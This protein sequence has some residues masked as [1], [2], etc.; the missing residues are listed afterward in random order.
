M[1]PAQLDHP[2]VVEPHDGVVWK[3]LAEVA[4]E[5]QNQIAQGHSLTLDDG[6]IDRELARASGAYA[7]NAAA[8][9]AG[10][11]YWP[12]PGHTWQPA[13]ARRDLVRSAALAIAEIERLDRAQ[14]V[15]ALAC[16]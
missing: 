2:V 13:D 14:A 1:S 11:L 6:Y 15:E 12:W 8:Q 16:P 4:A 9:T 7:L 5:R 3:V 10:S